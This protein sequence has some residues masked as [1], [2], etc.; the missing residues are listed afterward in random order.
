MVD[1]RRLMEILEKIN[2]NLVK[3]TAVVSLSGKDDKEKN[4]ILSRLGFS[5]SEIEEMTGVPA[6][7][8]RSHRRR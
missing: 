8:V 6:S 5:S 2:R 3:L 4:R 7:T 1:E